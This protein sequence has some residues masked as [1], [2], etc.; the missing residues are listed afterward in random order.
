M[1]EP[2][3]TFF[4][5]LSSLFNPKGFDEADKR[6][7]ESS[8][9]FG[10]YFSGLTAKNNAW[11]ESF[12]SVSR[13]SSAVS[14]ASF[15]SFF[16]M[17][18]KNFLNLETLAK[19]TFTGILSSFISTLSQMAVKSLTSG[20]FGA[21]DGGG[22][23]GGLLGSRRTGGPIE[24]TGPYMLHAGEFV[25]PPEVVS[26]IKQSRTLSLGADALTPAFEGGKSAAGINITVNTPI[27][28]QAGAQSSADAKKL[29]DEIAQATR[30]GVAWAVEA[31]KINYKIGRQK[32]GEVSL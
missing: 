8:D 10:N 3:S 7:K 18:S 17:T 32:S 6:T 16:D 26:A 13:R 19:Q 30:R 1:S 5:E 25:L 12:T 20:L 27:N 24:Q 23:L 9:N 14:Y 4:I 29:C 31:A 22:F 11:G 28:I 15:K 2:A 21:F